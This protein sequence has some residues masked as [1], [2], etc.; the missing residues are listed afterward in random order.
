[1]AKGKG[2]GGSKTGYVSKG[3]RLNVARKTM[4]QMKRDFGP[5]LLRQGINRLDEWKKGR[6][7]LVSVPNP[8][9][10]QRAKTMNVPATNK[11]IWGDPR[12]VY[13]IPVR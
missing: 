5:S 6:R 1:M 7:V 3:E 9:D 10:D 2:K 8:S 12:D 11:D 13:T 4:K